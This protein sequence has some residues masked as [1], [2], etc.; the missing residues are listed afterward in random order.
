MQGWEQQTS[1]LQQAAAKGSNYSDELKQKQ[2]Q[3][4]TY[5]D[6]KL[7]PYK[8]FVE[9]KMAELLKDFSEI[10]REA[11]EKVQVV[12]IYVNQFPQKQQLVE[13]TIYT[14]NSY[15]QGTTFFQS[16]HPVF[17]PYRDNLKEYGNFF[18]LDFKKLRASNMADL[19]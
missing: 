16:I 15:P 14:G 8:A 18:C 4:Q 19:L 13:V 17:V 10:C 11:T 6:S 12:T 7:A 9:Q 2:Q 3:L 1:I 5:H